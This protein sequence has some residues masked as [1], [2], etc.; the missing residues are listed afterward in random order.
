M[1]ATGGCTSCHNSD[2]GRAVPTTIHD[3]AK[4][5]PGDKPDVLADRM[6]PLSP[7]L[8]TAGSFFDDK[9]AVVNASLRGEK[10]G[11]ALP[12]LLDLAR[13][14][15]FLHDDSVKSLEDLFDPSRGET[16]P[17]PFYVKDS[18]DRNDLSAYLRSLDIADK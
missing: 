18:G 11:V 14:P 3:M 4:I 6:P 17:H 8:N 12:L 16:A 13:K 10:R 5:F 9:W 1:F 7:V 15:V 2:Q